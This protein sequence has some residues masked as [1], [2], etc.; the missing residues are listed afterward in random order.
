MVYNKFWSK[1]YFAL[2]LTMV[3]VHLLLLHTILFENTND[4]VKFY[5]T[6]ITIYLTIGHFLLQFFYA[7]LTKQIHQ[8]S[9]L[10]AHLQWRLKGWPFR[11]QS[12]LK[13]IA[14]FERLSANKKIGITLGPTVTLTFPIFAQV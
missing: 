7:Y 5:L 2:M 9:K 14:Y 11:L 4:H 1:P 12:K 13:L 6:I 3:P 10:L 8:N